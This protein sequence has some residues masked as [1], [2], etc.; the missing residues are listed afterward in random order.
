MGGLDFSKG[1][2]TD[3]MRAYQRLGQELSAHLPQAASRQVTA[4]AALA[5][6]AGLPLADPAQALRE[7]GQLLD[8]MLATAWRGGERATLLARLRAPAAGLCRGAAES[9]LG[10]RHPLP[11]AAAERAAAMQQLAWKLACN[12]ALALHE[13]CG[14]AGKVPRFGGRGPAAA[15]CAAGLC[16]GGQVLMW[17]YRQYR[18]PPPGTWRFMHAL[19]AAAEQLGLA[20][21]ACDDPCFHAGP[22][23]ARGIYAQALLLALANPYRFSATELQEA[24]AVTACLADRCVFAPAGAEGFAIDAASDAGPGYVASERAA[25]GTGSL[26]LDVKDVARTLDGCTG[27]ASAPEAVVELQRATGGTLAS[28]A[29]FLRRLASGWATVA[30]GHPRLPASHGLDVAFG[31][32]AAHYVVAGN[33]DFATFIAQVESDAT[34]LPVQQ[35]DGAWPAARA[36]VRPQ[37]LRAD[38]LDQSE[39][40]YRLRVQGADGQ[41]ARIGEIVAFAPA[42]EDPDEREWMVGVVRWLRLEDGH[43]RVGIQLLRRTARAAALRPLV[44]PDE[45]AGTLRALD[46]SDATDA[47]QLLLLLSHVAVPGVG[48]AEIT[49]PALAADWT[50]RA[51]IATWRMAGS[52]TLGPACFRVK[53][54]RT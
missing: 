9:L 16:H 29:G 14:P 49:L 47:G 54:E 17:A 1:E 26:V 34:G 53:L 37:P 52:E 25:P 51:T 10:E 22:T 40:G 6:V 31:M 4:R 28:R 24:R 33:H 2:G 30:R 35:Q 8:A 19:Y 12:D 48:A 36:P 38:V 11:P 7:I 18:A 43:A 50:S 23:T 39:G 3:G 20:T 15:A 44:D 5:V 42:A 41:L 45:G 32:H 13:L 46:V 27:S 21:Q